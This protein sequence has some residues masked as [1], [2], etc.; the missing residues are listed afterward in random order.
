[1]ERKEKMTIEERKTYLLKAC[2]NLLHKQLGSPYT[3]N[4]LAETV[5]YDG[6]ECDGECLMEDIASILYEENPNNE[7]DKVLDVLQTHY[8]YFGE[9]YNIT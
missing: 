5:N 8:I 7:N 4:L 6:A 2:F 1:M 3:L 9:T